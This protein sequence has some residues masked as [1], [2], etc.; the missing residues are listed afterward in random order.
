MYTLEYTQYIA[1]MTE[2]KI[3]MWKI[4]YKEIGSFRMSDYEIFS[5]YLSLYSIKQ[6]SFRPIWRNLRSNS[7]IKIQSDI[8]KFS[9][10][11]IFVRGILY[12]FVIF[13]TPHE[14][15]LTSDVFSFRRTHSIFLNENISNASSTRNWRSIKYLLLFLT[16]P[17]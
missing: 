7:A 14:K 12:L 8:W 3:C 4:E 1:R 17:F 13:G 5:N 11:H 9:N 16:L 10:G 15:F 2:M 6:S